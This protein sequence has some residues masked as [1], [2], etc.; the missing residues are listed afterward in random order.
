ML[1]VQRNSDIYTLSLLA[2]TILIPEHWNY[3]LI[4]SI[5]SRRGNMASL[6]FINY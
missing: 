3:K 2:I 5:D 4:R 6:D 1:I